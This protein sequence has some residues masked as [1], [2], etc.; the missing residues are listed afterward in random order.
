M[1]TPATGVPSGVT[2]TPRISRPRVNWTTTSSTGR[3]D[4]RSA[5]VYPV[6]V[7]NSA[8]P[9]PSDGPSEN[10][11]N[12]SVSTYASLAFETTAAESGTQATRAP[13]IAV[14]SEVS[15]TRPRMPARSTGPLAIGEGDGGGAAASGGISTRGMDST[16]PGSGFLQSCRLMS[17][18]TA[19]IS[20][21]STGHTSPRR[22]LR[23]IS[24]LH[25]RISVGTSRK[26]RCPPNE[27]PADDE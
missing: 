7:T 27:R 4:V 5:D 9:P 25:S 23:F 19:A 15:V 24:A 3:G 17:Q 11:P 14:P 18:R 16:M 8:A 22:L 12:A 26:P 1:R 6:R 20:V 13:E 10:L 2:T 21:T